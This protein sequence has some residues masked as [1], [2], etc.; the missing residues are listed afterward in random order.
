MVRAKGGQR[1]ET[2]VRNIVS[3][4]RVSIYLEG[5]AT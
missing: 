1:S 2:R 5:Q 3:G 4:K